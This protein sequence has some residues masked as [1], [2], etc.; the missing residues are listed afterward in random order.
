MQCFNFAAHIKQKRKRNPK[1]ITAINLSCTATYENEILKPFC[2]GVS[3]QRLH[4]RYKLSRYIVCARPAIY[5]IYNNTFL[6]L[7][8]LGSAATSTPN[9]QRRSSYD[10]RTGYQSSPPVYIQWYA[11]SL[12]P[13]N[14]KF[15]TH[16]CM[17][18]FSSLR[19]KMGLCLIILATV[20]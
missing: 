5:S 13:S 20:C 9:M 4:K 16:L 8:S 10:A 18:S 7:Y 11:C 3:A 6:P 1:I 17:K 2:K 14:S 15:I 12:I 19:A